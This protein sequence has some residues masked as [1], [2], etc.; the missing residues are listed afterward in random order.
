M[1]T[2]QKLGWTAFLL[3]LA[4]TSAA[5]LA[6]A[7]HLIIVGELWEQ[8][9]VTGVPRF[10]IGLLLLPVS[11]IPIVAGLRIFSEWRRRQSRARR[12]SRSV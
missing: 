7:V 2:A 5:I 6:Y 8:T 9:D 1:T 3:V 4:L 12:L 10:A 11:A